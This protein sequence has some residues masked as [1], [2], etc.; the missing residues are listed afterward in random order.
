MSST[1]SSP[2][3]YS[4]RLGEEQRR[5]EIGAD[6]K[7]RAGD[8]A[9]RVVDV[10]AERVPALVAVEERRKDAQRQRR[11]HEQRAALQRGENQIAELLRDRMVLG[12]L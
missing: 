6:A 10:I 1:I 2:P 11:G 4:S 5:R 7:R 8:L 3:S 12:Q 9:N